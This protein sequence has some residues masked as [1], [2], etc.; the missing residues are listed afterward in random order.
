MMT[1]NSYNLDRTKL[2]D[3]KFLFELEMELYF[4]TKSSGTKTARAQSP[5][6]ILK[7]PASMAGSLFDRFFLNPKGLL[8]SRYSI[9]TKFLSFDPCEHC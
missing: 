4:D 6:K 3:R 1:N 8:A 7:S 5:F 2:P 9:C